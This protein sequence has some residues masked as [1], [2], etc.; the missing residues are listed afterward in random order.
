M[1]CAYSAPNPV[2]AALAPPQQLRTVASDERRSERADEP[3]VEV[4]L[5]S[6]ARRRVGDL[7]GIAPKFCAQKFRAPDRQSAARW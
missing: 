1:G 5:R 4:V 2:Q 7:R 3:R 6:R